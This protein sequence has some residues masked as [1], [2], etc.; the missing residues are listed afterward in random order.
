MTKEFVAF[1]RLDASDVNAYLVNRP[2]QNAII[3]GAFEINQRNFTSTTTTGVFNFDR[4]RTIRAGD[5][6]VTTTAEAFSPG[7]EPL[8]GFGAKNFLRVNTSGQ[9]SAAV[10][11]QIQ[12]PIENVE[13]FAGQTITVSFYAKSSSG[14]PK[15]FTDIVQ[16][17]GSGGSGNVINSGGTVIIGTTW[18]RYSITFNMDS[19]VGKTVGLGSHLNF[20]L[21]LS[22]GSDFNSRTNSLGIQSNTFDIWGVQIE[23][24]SVATPFRR[25]ANSIQGELA[26][27]QRYYFRSTAS[28]AFTY[29]G[30]AYTQNTTTADA[31]IQL[32]V[33]MRV[34]PTSVESS[35]LGFSLPSDNAMYA[36]SSVTLNSV[37][38]NTNCLAINY[39]VATTTANVLGRLLANNNA[40]AFIACSAEL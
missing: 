24:G 9:T 37:L 3:N 11:T 33:T 38:S 26:A 19:I 6:T 31:S 1:T 4:W 17:F 34:V 8:V 18:A 5:G 36:A 28:G 10:A 25:N 21:F 29:F 7:T 39:T 30:L 14:N 13:T 23:A 12:Q 22:A 35:N 32:P 20:N 16:N 2:L 27:C 40:A 15:I